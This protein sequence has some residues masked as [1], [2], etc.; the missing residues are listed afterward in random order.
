M[1]KAISKTTV[2]KAVEAKPK[3][4][5]GGCAGSASNPE[6]STFG[7]SNDST[8][9]GNGVN[10]AKG[11]GFK[12][13]PKGRHKQPGVNRNTPKPTS[14]IKSKP[15]PIPTRNPAPVPVAG[16]PKPPIMLENPIG[17]NTKF[18]PIKEKSVYKK[19]GST[20]KAKSGGVAGKMK[21][22]GAKK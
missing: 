18:M 3:M 16:G 1:K 8:G 6:C 9:R 11:S 21:C 14:N 17:L 20:C 12:G 4:Q 7:N 2:K 10:R 5:K 13:F 19:G 15:A 22:G